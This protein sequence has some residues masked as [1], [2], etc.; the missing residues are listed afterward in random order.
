MI[1]SNTA[2]TWKCSFCQAAETKTW[3]IH[4]L[5]KLLFPLELLLIELVCLPACHPTI[6]LGKGVFCHHDVDV[7]GVENLSELL[8][9]CFVGRNVAHLMMRL[10]WWRWGHRWE[11]NFLTFGCFMFGCSLSSAAFTAPVTREIWTACLKTLNI[12]VFS[13]YSSVCHPHW[14]IALLCLL[15]L[16]WVINTPT[17]PSNSQKS[18]HSWH[19]PS[20]QLLQRGPLKPLPPWMNVETTSKYLIPDVHKS[21]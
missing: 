19:K 12:N 8:Q 6:H 16:S 15:H 20:Q 3:K 13:T 11:E 5:T 17:L 14:Q 1:T 7:V 2:S 10:I 4:L 18:F 21:Y 9:E